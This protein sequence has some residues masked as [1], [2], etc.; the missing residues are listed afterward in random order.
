[1][2]CIGKLPFSDWKIFEDEN[3]GV[4]VDKKQ[5]R[6]LWQ[7]KFAGRLPAD[8][9]ERAKQGRFLSYRGYPLELISRVLRGD[10]AAD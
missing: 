5:L 7:R 6:E 4:N 10:S 8:A 9:K 3:S 2:W 1:M